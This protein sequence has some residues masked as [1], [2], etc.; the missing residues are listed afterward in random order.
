MTSTTAPPQLPVRFPAISTVGALRRWVVGSLV[1]NM[2]IVVTGAVVRLTSSGLGCPT[3]P[4]CD[5]TSYV[6]Q[7]ALGVHGVIEF[8]NRMLTFVL[9]LLAAGTAVTAFRVARAAAGSVTRVPWLAVAVGVGIVLQGVVGGITVLT[10]LNPWIVALH[11]V[12]SVVLISVCVV[13]LHAVYDIAPVVVSTR[14]RALVLAIAAAT[15]VVI[16]LGTTVTGAGPN[17]GAGGASRNGLDPVLATRVHAGAVWILLALTVAA[18]VMTRSRVV[19]LL[20]LVQLV[21]G[22]IGYVQYVTGLPAVGVALHM[23]GV[24]A[25]TAMT[26]HVVL[27]LREV[28]RPAIAG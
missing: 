20:L 1:M 27:R 7:A 19:A 10:G 22:V 15:V 3:W 13:M 4:R 18:F 17:S 24:A 26:A 14:V 5:A 9:I 21:Q 6:P 2:L 16:L 23:A 8:A 12:L 11:M 25:L 28:V